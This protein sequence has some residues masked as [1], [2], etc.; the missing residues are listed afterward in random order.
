MISKFDFLTCTIKHEHSSD[1]TKDFYKALSTLKC[2]ML[3][4]ELIEKMDAV[5][6]RRGYEQA[7]MYEYI[8]L[9]LP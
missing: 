3:L 2:T 5:G 8:T 9:M 1:S 6:R 4:D 7:L